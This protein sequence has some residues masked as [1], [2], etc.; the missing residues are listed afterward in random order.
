MHN[1]LVTLMNESF[2][3]TKGG[4]Q[5]K[6]R[7]IHYKDLGIRKYPCV[8]ADTYAGLS[9]HTISR[10]GHGD[11]ADNCTPL[12]ELRPKPT[13]VVEDMVRIASVYLV[14]EVLKLKHREVK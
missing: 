14:E 6:R 13:A 1:R 4:S 8:C 2:D 9:E 12:K 5:C 10:W 11:S 7:Q 3:P